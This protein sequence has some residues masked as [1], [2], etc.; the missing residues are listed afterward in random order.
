MITEVTIE[1]RQ[2]ESAA[3]KKEE[4]F[5]VYRNTV[6]DV[7]YIIRQY[8]LTNPAEA[9]ECVKKLVDNPRLMKSKT[10]R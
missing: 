5:D 3:E 10:K 4:L 1:D 9:L 7:R 6:K 2:T 8:G